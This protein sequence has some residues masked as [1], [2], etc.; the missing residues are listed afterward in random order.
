M[1]GL[2]IRNTILAQ[3][4]TRKILEY[5]NSCARMIHTSM[6]FMYHSQGIAL[7]SFAIKFKTDE[8]GKEE[9]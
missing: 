5:K 6:F 7:S 1:N 3:I 4:P 9:F 2:T 8:I